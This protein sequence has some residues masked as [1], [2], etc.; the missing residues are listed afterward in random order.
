MVGEPR[1]GLEREDGSGG[2]V[3]L[4]LEGQLPGQCREEGTDPARRRLLDPLTTQ[5]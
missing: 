5:Q 3:G 4:E 1:C 2:N